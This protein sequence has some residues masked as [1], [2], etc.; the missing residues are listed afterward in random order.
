[1]LKSVY[2][3]VGDDFLVV[4]PTVTAVA[5]LGLKVYL[6][7]TEDELVAA[8]IAFGGVHQCPVVVALN[9]SAGLNGAGNFTQ[10]LTQIADAVV[11]AALLFQIAPFSLRDTVFGNEDGQA[12]VIVSEVHSHIEQTLGIVGESVVVGR[13]GF[14]P[15]GLITS[16][17]GFAELCVAGIVEVYADE[18]N[19]N[20]V[21]LQ[22]LLIALRQLTHIVGVVR[23]DLGII[24]LIIASSHQPA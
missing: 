11:V 7:Q 8:G 1:V 6:N 5:L 16:G 14:V 15:E 2:H 19:G 22:I 24:P 18:V 20:E 9:V 4:I 10:M 17:V 23:Q 3:T 12:G 13:I 21:L